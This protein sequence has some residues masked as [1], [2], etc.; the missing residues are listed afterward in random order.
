MQVQQAGFIDIFFIAPLAFLILVIKTLDMR[1]VQSLDTFDLTPSA[2]KS[3]CKIW[4]VLLKMLSLL[5]SRNFQVS[6]LSFDGEKGVA[7]MVSELN[8]DEIIVSLTGANCLV[9]EE[10]RRVIE[11]GLS[12]VTNKVLQLFATYRA[13]GCINN[14]VSSSAFDGL[15][16]RQRFTGRKPDA[17]R[18]V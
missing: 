7:A 11:C 13:V 8:D 9:P 15:L 1:F 3:K 6:V 16:P 18:D 5:K 14:Y 4:S 2:R 10:D 17:K 12:F